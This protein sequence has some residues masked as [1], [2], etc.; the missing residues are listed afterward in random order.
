MIL[1]LDGSLPPGTSG[2]PL[3]VHFHQREQGQVKAGTLGVQVGKKKIAAPSG[4]SAVFVCVI[5]ASPNGRPSIFYIAHHIPVR[6]LWTPRT[7]RSAMPH[8]NFQEKHA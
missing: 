5:N 7:R 8:A 4:G 2:P 1:Y 6:R 3:Q